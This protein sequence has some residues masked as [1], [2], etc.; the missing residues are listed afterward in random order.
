MQPLSYRDC[1]EAA[2]S[3]HGAEHGPPAVA[4]LRGERITGFFRPRPGLA[5]LLYLAAVQGRV[6]WHSAD[7]YVLL[8]RPAAMTGP[9]PGRRWA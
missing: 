5:V 9:P 3:A 4:R 6:V 2:R 7:A 8:E 1:R